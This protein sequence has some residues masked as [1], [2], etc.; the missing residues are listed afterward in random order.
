MRCFNQNCSS[1]PQ[2]F[3]DCQNNSVLFCLEHLAHHISQIS[4]IKHPIQ[5]IYK[6]IPAEER[7]HYLEKYEQI[8]EI[9]CKTEISINEMLSKIINLFSNLKTDEITYFRKLRE[10]LE[11]T[12]K[13]LREGGEEEKEIVVPG[14]MGLG[15]EIKSFMAESMK[16][17]LANLE[18]EI[19]D[20]CQKNSF[21]PSYFD[22]LF[23]EYEEF[24][25]R[26]DNIYYGKGNLEEHL[27]CFKNGTKILFEFNTITL[28]TREININ[29]INE[30]QGSLC[31]LCTVPNNKLFHAGSYSPYYDSVYLIDLNTFS[32]EV[33]PKWRIRGV[34]TATY[35][36]KCVYTFGG[37][38]SG[39]T[40]MNL[41][42]KFDL[43][44]KKWTALANLPD[45]AQDIH[46]IPCR[47]FIILTFTPNSSLLKYFTNLNK[48]ETLASNISCNY[49]N[50]FIRDHGKYYLIAVNQ[51]YVSNEENLNSWSKLPKT[52]GVSLTHHTSKPV[53]RGRNAYFL[54][55]FSGNNQIWKFDIDEVHLEVISGF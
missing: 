2:Y 23:L 51:V 32:V 30:A 19:K 52:L 31:P 36:E 16:A 48:Y 20:L 38:T 17:T 10:R 40:R 21:I 42:D 6:D 12:M 18:G 49:Q 1:I 33:L 41:S 14:Y 26:D 24:L 44:E 15:N 25:E 45:V 4:S 37:Q 54:S 34:A 43:G 13:K 39:G 22:K 28:K 8:F 55:N 3:C 5:S 47:T 11:K 46:A 53:I 27:Y 29:V 35:F 7:K 50:M 9:V